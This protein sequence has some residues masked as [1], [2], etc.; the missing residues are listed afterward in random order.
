MNRIR[1]L[2]AEFDP[3]EFEHGPVESVATVT[4]G[5]AT[6]PSVLYLQHCENSARAKA[7]EEAA[8]QLLLASWAAGVWQRSP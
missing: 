3:E 5:V 2:I 7:V 6:G 8:K 1:R 4:V